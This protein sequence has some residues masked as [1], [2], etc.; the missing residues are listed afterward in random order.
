M[1]DYT[2]YIIEMVRKIS[3]KKFIKRIYD[4]VSYLYY[5]DK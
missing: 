3:N 2:E 1:D 4:L 5:I